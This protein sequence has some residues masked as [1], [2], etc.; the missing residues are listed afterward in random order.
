MD[1][2]T[3]GTRLYGYSENS[4]K[5]GTKLCMY[6]RRGMNG[7]E[8]ECKLGIIKSSHTVVHGP[9]TVKIWELE[10]GK[11]YHYY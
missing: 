6:T 7:E 4:G 8:S 5:H 3:Y 1:E 9:I 2:E 11:K 10:H